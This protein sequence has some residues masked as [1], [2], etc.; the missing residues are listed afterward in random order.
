MV[1]I[2][3]NTPTHENIAIKRLMKEKEIKESELN[4]SEKFLDTLMRA[5][6]IYRPRK[7]YVKII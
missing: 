2:L 1:P 4:V 7:G 3:T 5:G 6:V